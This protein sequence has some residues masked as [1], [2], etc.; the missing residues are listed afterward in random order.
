MLWL[1]FDV[2]TLRTI[3]IEWEYIM[4]CDDGDDNDDDDDDCDDHN[5]DIKH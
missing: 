5:D 2:M 1:S 3:R 4:L